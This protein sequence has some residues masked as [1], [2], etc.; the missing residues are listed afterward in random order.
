MPNQCANY[1]QS[2]L[3][4]Y[5][6]PFCA[7]NV[8]W[9]TLSQRFPNTP[10]NNNTGITV[11]FTNTI[12][13]DPDQYI[14]SL[15]NV[16]EV[17][18]FSNFTGCPKA[19]PIGNDIVMSNQAYGN[20][21]AHAVGHVFQLY[22]VQGSLAAGPTGPGSSSLDVSNLMCSGDETYCP[23]IEHPGAYLTAKQIIAA[24]KSLNLWCSL[25]TSNCPVP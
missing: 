2:H 5:I 12:T 8:G 3:D 24:R 19:A 23:D 1:L 21:L 18:P 15:N 10:G 7:P 17:V 20:V 22:D 4:N 11:L 13:E 25:A 16:I 6:T 14:L 9:L